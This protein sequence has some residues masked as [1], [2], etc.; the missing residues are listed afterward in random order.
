MTDRVRKKRKQKSSTDR[1]RTRAAL[2]NLFGSTMVTCSRCKDRKLPDCLVAESSDS[3]GNCL[4]AGNTSCDAWG[5]DDAAVQRL[6][7]QKNQLD[8]EEQFTSNA[9]KAANKVLMTALAKADRLRIQRQA[10]ERKALAMFHQ[11]GEV[12]REQERGASPAAP[13]PDPSSLPSALQGFDP[14]LSFLG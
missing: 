12:L 9:I 6:V 2:S 5:Y 10:L 4:A 14:L 1:R 8:R 13:P 3:C 11:E 7:A